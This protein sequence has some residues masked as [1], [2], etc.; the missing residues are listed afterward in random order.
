MKVASMLILHR[1]PGLIEKT[2]FGLVLAFL[3]AAIATTHV[4]AACIPAKSA[5]TYNVG[6]QQ[7]AY[8][9]TTIPGTS[10]T[11]VNK[12]WSGGSDYTGTCNGLYF[13]VPPGSVGLALTLG[14]C[15]PTGLGCPGGHLIVQ[16]IVIGVGGTPQQMLVTRVLEEFPPG[17]FDFSATSHDMCNVPCPVM[18]EL[19]P[20]GT[21]RIV[22]LSIGSVTACAF[23]GSAGS[24]T[25]WN[26]VSKA[27]ATNPGVFAAPYGVRSF[28]P[29]PG[30]GATIGSAALDCSD[31]ALDQWVTMQLMTSAGGGPTVCPAI[32][33]DCKCA[34]LPDGAACDDFIACTTNDTCGGGICHG[35]ATTSCNDENLCTD[36]SCNPAT[37]CEFTNNAIACSDGN[38]CTQLDT[39][40]AG[41]CIGSNPVT[42]AAP[43]QCHTTP[44][45]CAP[46]N[47][48]CAYPAKTDG[49]GCD[50][51]NPCTAQ[52]ACGGGVCSAPPQDADGDAVNDLCD[53]CPALANPSQ[54]DTDGDGDGDVCDNCLTVANPSQ[55]D[56]D[57]DGFGA[58]CD[59]DDANLAIHPGVPDTTCNG[60]D[61][62]C[63]GQVDE[64]FPGGCQCS[65][66][67]GGVVGWWPGDGNPNDI[68]GSNHGALTNGATYAAGQV[69]QAFS[70]DG[71]DDY[72]GNV[73]TVTTYSFV[74]NTGVFTIT[75]WINLADLNALTQQAITANTGTTVEDG[76]FFLWENSSGQ[77]RLRVGLMNG[78]NGAPVIDVSSVDNVITTPG[79]HHVAVVGDGAVITFFVD[80]IAKGGG[81]GFGTLGTV[82]STRPLS[83]GR[84]PAAFP[85]CQFS[86]R[87]DEVQIFSRA[88][89]VAEIQAIAN[90]GTTG[91]CQCIDA[92][93]DGYG[94]QAGLS[95]PSGSV[96][97]CNDSVSTIRPGA[98]E[99][100]NGVDDNCNG[101]FDDGLPRSA[102]Y[103]DADNDTFGSSLVT[104]QSCATPAGYVSNNTDCNDAN[105]AIHPGVPD[106]ICDG[107]DDNCNGPLDD[108]YAPVPT[109]WFATATSGAPSARGGAA[110]TGTGSLAFVWGGQYTNPGTGGR[111]DPSTDTWSA[112]TTVGAPAGRTDATAV[113]SGSQVLL[114][115]GRTPSLK[116]DGVRYDPILDTWQGIAPF[117]SITNAR[118]NHSAVWT[119]TRMIIWGGLSGLTPVATGGSYDPS[120]DTWITLA[121]APGFSVRY[122][123]TAVWT[124]T[125]MIIWGG[126][127]GSGTVRNDGRRYDPGTNTWDT[128]AAGPLAARFGH[129]AV[130]T[131]SKMIV[132]GGAD[133]N[134]N[135]FGDGAAYDPATDSWTSLPTA[136]A[137]TPR[138]RHFAVWTGSEM[139]VWGGFGA[140]STLLNDGARYNPATNAWSPLPSQSSPS[141]R[142]SYV[143]AWASN[144]STLVVWGGSDG[145]S[146]VN[147]G[148]RYFAAAYNCGVGACVRQSGTRCAAGT[149]GYSCTP[150]PSQPEIC[151]GLDDD[152]NNAVD[153]GAPPAAGRPLLVEAKSGATA[154]VSWAAVPF[155]ASYDVVTGSLPTLRNGL[156]NYTTSTTACLGNDGAGTSVP[157]S[158]IV[159]VGGGI[160]HLVRAVSTCGG[161]GAYD[162]SAA[163]QSGSRDAEIAASAAPCP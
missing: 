56:V 2:V 49:T 107:I 150:G 86:G 28:L 91:M 67:G 22:T 26:I 128:V 156:G 43:D 145:V 93:A 102:F 14:D 121:S 31:P 39:C 63:N 13:G 58:A 54:G 162:E 24:L 114:W 87:V 110:A 105:A 99:L 92:D 3:I 7:L 16:A 116:N 83:I 73:G 163:S 72:V 84:C 136:G 59:C 88:L 115:G 154:V 23:D 98:T 126:A 108:E 79:W 118:T 90:S 149:I 137:P 148:G 53:N 142:S 11:L 159:P 66:L 68:R 139:I 33:V 112:T 41:T 12:I 40:S 35:V 17:F 36:D 19:I 75:A 78:T 160:W 57:A 132:W 161:N 52:D 95:C 65:E 47:G 70:F 157:D 61:E 158:Q 94:L 48:S 127:T 96:A 138:H 82:A 45:T 29:A 6:T 62:N 32:R 141:G 74:Q 10:A 18:T 131:G 140:G 106:A 51:G 144:S 129:T 125:R 38:A 104:V 8:W 81:G 64:S 9:H 46:A 77:K 1:N 50:D 60:I 5:S 133:V 21:A 55:A 25:G 119:G 89:G 69:G 85:E 34:T 37:G 146:Q 103:R 20:N 15:T 147:T 44:G 42:C 124:G 80:G 117:G 123:H 76:H 155:A 120:T 122:D 152:C 30:G 100:C 27:S 135:P 151:N 130:W 71:I 113:W 101:Q 109:G 134:S 143:G 111:Y 4:S 97:D 153:D